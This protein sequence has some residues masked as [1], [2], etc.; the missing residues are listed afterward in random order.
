MLK[1]YDFMK[2]TTRNNESFLLSDFS[3]ASHQYLLDIALY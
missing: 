3:H 1:V 2:Q